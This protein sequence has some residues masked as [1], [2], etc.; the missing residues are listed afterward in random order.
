MKAKIK[1][2][3]NSGGCPVWLSPKIGETTLTMLQNFSI[4]LERIASF[5]ESFAASNGPGDVPC[6]I[7]RS[8]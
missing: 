2:E 7:I 8:F 5:D 1:A 3:I 6:V 4:S